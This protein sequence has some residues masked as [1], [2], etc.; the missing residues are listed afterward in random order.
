MLAIALLSLL[1]IGLTA[2]AIDEFRSDDDDPAPEDEPDEPQE[3]T[4]PDAI[5][6]SYPDDQSGDVTIRGT[7][8]DDRLD[9]LVFDGL[10]LEDRSLDVRAGRGS[11]LVSV[12]DLSGTFSG[13]VGDDFMIAGGGEDQTLYGG[14]GDDDITVTEAAGGRLFGG[15]GNDYLDITH[16][17]TADENTV[18]DGGNGFDFLV[19]KV[20][21][22]N[23]TDQSYSVLRGSEDNDGFDFLIRTNDGAY[24][25]AVRSG[26]LNQTNAA[27]DPVVDGGIMARIADFGPGDDMNI[28]I[29]GADIGADSFHDYRGFE[30]IERDGG[31]DLKLIW[32]GLRPD[33]EGIYELS[34]I[35]RFEGV[36]ELNPA[37]LNITAPA[38]GMVGT[39]GD[40]VIE[41][42]SVL[43]PDRVLAGDGDD[44][45]TFLGNSPITLEGGDG[46]DTLTAPGDDGTLLGQNGDDVLIG[47]HAA[48]MFGGAGDD[49]LS[50]DLTDG[51]HDTPANV[52]GD[53]GDDTLTA[54]V[55]LGHGVP[56]TSYGF[57]TGGAGSDEINVMVNLVAY[58]FDVTVPEETLDVSTGIVLTDF[59]PGEDILTIEI[60][61]GA[62]EEDREMISAEIIRDAAGRATLVMSFA[63]TASSPA[64][65]GAMRLGDN[66]NITLD[67]IAFIQS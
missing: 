5:Q 67:D 26:T 56:D 32:D 45:I 60:A 39:P 10:D 11:D 40:D 8:G 48:Q 38:P 42:D 61:R 43:A 7:D 55:D 57:L 37:G 63:A 9:N 47:G 34:S 18:A 4:D 17:P 20:S 62:G 25:E 33:A 53:A 35:I 66:P 59:T 15:E 3:P 19:A 49:S 29:R 13:G 24:L 27:G 51:L 44:N 21:T 50:V 12:G 28:D 14:F 41:I 2:F 30:L 65:E 58:S 54:A 1:G 16:D 22:P 52:H 36:T 46:D 31:T 6:V 64:L 23:G